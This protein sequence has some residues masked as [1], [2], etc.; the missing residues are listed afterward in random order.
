MPETPGPP[1]TAERE[2]ARQPADPGALG[3]FACGV[4]APDEWLKHGAAGIQ[5]A[6]ASRT[7]VIG[8]AAALGSMLVVAR[9]SDLRAAL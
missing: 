6:D 4:P 2:L 5:A 8:A 1:R 3:G 7:V 9:P